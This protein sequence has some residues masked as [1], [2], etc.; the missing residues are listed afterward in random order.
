MKNDLLNKILILGTIILVIES[1]IIP[2]VVSNHNKVELEYPYAD[3]KLNNKILEIKNKSINFFNN[4][5]LNSVQKT[6]PGVRISGIIDEVNYDPSGPNIIIN[7]AGNMSDK[8]GPY[9]RPPGESD[10]LDEDNEGN[11]RDGYYTND[12]RQHEDWIYINLTIIDDD[13]VNDAWLHWYDKTTGNWANNSY[14][15]ENTIGNFWEFNSSDIISVESGHDYSFDIVANDSIGDSNLERWMKTGLGGSLTRRY[16]QF[17][18]IPENIS[19]CPFYLRSYTS[20]TGKYDHA[21]I[22][23]KDRLHHDQGPDGTRS[24]SGFLDSTLP[25]DN[26][27]D[28]Y[29]TTFTAYGFD[30]SIC[31]KPFTLNNIYFH[32]WYASRKDD[33]D[34]AGWGKTRGSFDT[35]TINNYD[36]PGKN[37]SRANVSYNSNDRECYLD[38]N[39][40]QTTPTPFTDNDIYELLLLFIEN[41]WARADHTVTIKTLSSRSILSFV[42]FNVPDNATLI[43][44]DSDEDGLNDWTELYVT[45]TSPFLDD[46]DND[47]AT[48]YEEANGATYGYWNSD[49]NDYE[50]TTDYRQIMTIDTDEIYYGF[51]NESVQFTISVLGGQPPYTWLWDFGDNSYSTAQDP[52]H[53]YNQTGTYLINVTVADSDNNIS[54]DNVNAIIQLPVVWVDDDFNVTTPGWEITHFNK[55]Q[56]GVDNGPVGGCVYVYN[57]TYY[58]HVE[59]DKSIKL[60]GE[61]KNRT[62][63]DG[64]ENGDVVTISTDNVTISGFTIQ[65][66]GNWD[67]GIYYAIFVQTDHNTI[68]ENI[69]TNCG[70]GI[71]LEMDSCCNTITTNRIN[72]SLLAIKLDGSYIEGPSINSIYNNTITG[73]ALGIYLLNYAIYNSIVENNIITSGI[74]ECGISLVGSSTNHIVGNCISN[75]YC[76]I[77]ATETASWEIESCNNEIYHNNLINNTYN[78]YDVNNNTW[79]HEVLHEGNYWDDFDEPSEGAWDNNSDGIVDISYYIP[80]GSNQDLYP[81]INPNGWFVIPGDINGDGVVNIEDFLALIAAWGPC[82]DCNDCPADFDGDCMV[83]VT[84]F[85]I[86]LENWS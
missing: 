37:S 32:Y 64:S 38:T 24:D 49:P 54:Y 67:V 19:Y 13:G 58:E 4:E 53:T 40:L 50:N 71:V 77:G 75:Y 27:E 23:K 61:D 35:N 72:N 60:L 86:L 16:V 18:C 65:N 5:E 6:N 26:I 82:G 68:S 79:Y 22:N 56:T 15:F 63:I 78:A 20:E 81:Y 31:I 41:A 57:G 84:D 28:R 14:Q 42:I 39:L 62:I 51:I 33:L 29:C 9:W 46:T 3:L 21:D 80:G 44:L 8:G 74:S 85:L 47:G 66:S 69:I 55:I 7:F 34:I 76:G 1:C 25:G 36:P 30:E 11:W 83:G 59:I 17:D 12:S 73:C 45:Y 2:T 43:L 70:L 48:D 52:M 10:V